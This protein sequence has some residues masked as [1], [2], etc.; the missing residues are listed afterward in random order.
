MPTTPDLILKKQFKKSKAFKNWF[1]EVSRDTRLQSLGLDAYLA[2]PLQ[3]LCR[4]PLYLERLRSLYNNKDNHKEKEEVEKSLSQLKYVIAAVNKHLHDIQAS[5]EVA[6]VNKELVAIRRNSALNASHETVADIFH[7]NIE[8][9]TTQSLII[10][11]TTKCRVFGDFRFAVVPASYCQSWHQ[12]EGSHAKGLLMD[13]FFILYRKQRG[14][15]K[16]SASIVKSMLSRKA[17]KSST[18]LTGTEVIESM[19]IN[20]GCR[21]QRLGCQAS[22]LNGKDELNAIAISNHNK[23][24]FS[25]GRFC[26]H[27]LANNPTSGVTSLLIGFES[28]NEL[29]TWYSALDVLINPCPPTIPAK[30][31]PQGLKCVDESSTMQK[32]RSKKYCNVM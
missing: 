20:T 5:K 13:R 9:Q 4:Y 32:P 27:L 21:I 3:R 24:P 10:S 12:V 28:R 29:E 18:S 8:K 6:A 23:K 17:R 7:N 15:E 2:K 26:F 22:C 30:T 11:P 25:I 19:T 31:Y 16:R 1:N 14:F